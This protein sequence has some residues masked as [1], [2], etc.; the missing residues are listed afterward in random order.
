[1]LFPIQELNKSSSLTKHSAIA[2][3]KRQKPFCKIFEKSRY[4]ALLTSYP[5]NLW[6]TLWINCILPLKSGI[7]TGFIIDC[8]FFNR[9]KIILLNQYVTMLCYFIQPLFNETESKM[10][11]VIF[12]IHACVKNNRETTKTQYLVLFNK[13]IN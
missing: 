13:A 12:F 10:N 8:S 5:Q 7:E 2:K 9:F 6:I 4:S 11:N 1:M 3:G